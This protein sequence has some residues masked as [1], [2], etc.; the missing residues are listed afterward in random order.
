[1]IEW[2]LAIGVLLIIEAVTI[3]CRF[4]MKKESKDFHANRINKKWKKRGIHWHHFLIGLAIIPLAFLFR[5]S[6]EL[7]LFNIG[8]GIFLSDMVHHFIVLAVFTGSPEFCLIYRN[9]NF[10]DRDEAVS[11]RRKI[12]KKITKRIE[13]EV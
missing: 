11:G 3:F 9:K 2:K 5:G 1:M 10:I 4:A 6:V 12:L 7:G 13:R 8:L